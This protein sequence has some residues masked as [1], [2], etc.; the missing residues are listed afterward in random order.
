MVSRDDP[1]VWYEKARGRVLDASE[2]GELTAADVSAI[3]EVLDALDIEID[4]IRFRTNGGYIKTLASKT[5]AN[6]TTRLRLAG[7]DLSS[8]LLN[9]DTQSIHGLIE[10]LVDG[11]SSV[12]PAD[13]Y[14]RGTIGQYQSALKA[15]YRFHGG[16][17]VV[18][19]EIKITPPAKTSI[20]SKDMFSVEEVLALRDAIDSP[21]ERCLFELLANT[22]QRIRAIQTLRIKDVDLEA[23]EITLNDE[24]EGLKGASGVRPLLGVTPFVEKWLNVHPTYFDPSSF[25]ITPLPTHGGGGTPGGMLTQESMRYHLR[26]SLASPVSGKT[27]IRTCSDTISRPSRRRNTV[28]MTHTSN[29]FGE[30]R[31]GQE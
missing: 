9:Q 23:G 22:G 2:R 5:L 29:T 4:S 8:G 6:Y 11:S 13:G 26:K 18:P 20:S 10:G 30:I 16:H 19:E 28:S 27:S 7:T 25:L 3:V 14:A 21:R 1:R 12:G 31:R 15:F 24:E 17:Q